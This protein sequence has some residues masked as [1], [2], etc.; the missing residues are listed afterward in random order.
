MGHR[1]TT[2]VRVLFIGFVVASSAS[3]SFLESPAS[4][5]SPS[6]APLPSALQL[7]PQGT[8][9]LDNATGTMD[10]ELALRPTADLDAY[11]NAV[12]TP[13]NPLYHQF[14]TNAEIAT[15]FGATPSTI[16]QLTSY[17]ASFGLT[18]TVGPTNLW[19][20]LRGPAPSIARAFGTSI[21]NAVV[22]GIGTRPEAIST[23]VVPSRFLT[24]IESVVGLTDYAMATN[25]AIPA[26]R[27]GPILHASDSLAQPA[28][29]VP[30]SGSAVCSAVGSNGGDTPSVLQSGY[31]FDPL[32]ANG[33]FGQGTTVGLVEFAD[34]A[35]SDAA[36]A[37]GCFGYS[38]TLANVN[39]DGGNTSFSVGGTTEVTA[40]IDTVMS[41]APKANID[42]YLAPNST[43]GYEAILQQWI[44][45][46]SVPILSSS[47][48]FCEGLAGSSS[49]ANSLDT[50]LAS[51]TASG[52]T[53]VVASG[54]YGPSGSQCLTQA[55][56][57]PA[58][59][60]H[61]LAVGGTSL[62]QYDTSAEVTWNDF[63][64]SAF[65]NNAPASG[66]GVST[67]FPA[68]SWQTTEGPGYLANCP[69][70]TY[71]SGCR[72]V[73][74]VS[75]NADPVGNYYS[76]Y[77]TQGCTGGW[78]G[79]GGTSLAT[80]LW[81]SGL[82][83]AEEACPSTTFGNVDPL[84]YQGASTQPDIFNDI[85][86]GTTANTT[87][88]QYFKAAVGYDMATGLG[89]P[90]FANLVDYLCGNSL[91]TA[92][93]GTP[94]PVSSVYALPAT[95]QG[96]SFST[97][98]GF[99]NNGFGTLV[100]SGLSSAG[101]ANQ[102]SGL[103]I[104]STDCGTTL[105]PGE[106]CT[107][108]V[109]G[110]ST[111]AGFSSA[112]VTLDGANPAM[113]TVGSST[114][115]SVVD[116]G[117]GLGQTGNFGSVALGTTATRT[118]TFANGSQ[119][120]SVTFGATP[121]TITGSQS[122]SIASTTCTSAS[123]SPGQTCQ[124]VVSFQPTQTGTL[125]SATL[126]SVSTAA[127]NVSIA[128][129]GAPANSLVASA[130]AVSIG[131]VGFGT[132]SS[133]KITLTA[134]GE[135]VTLGSPVATL[136]GSSDFEWS[137]GSCVPGSVLQANANC[138]LTVSYQPTHL[139][140]ENAS[141]TIH[142][143]AALGVSS[144]SLNATGVPQTAPPGYRM[145]NAAGQV[146]TFGELPNYGEVT[147][148]LNKPIVGMAN[149]PN[150]G[151]YWLVASDGGIFTFGDAQFYGSM[152]GHPLNKPVVGMT[153]TSD[154]AGYWMVASDGGIFTFGDAQFYGS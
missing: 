143:N 96:S 84:L 126:T 119:S 58:D 138:T 66:G 54:D 75:A 39:V 37:A 144:V 81:A 10:V 113:V 68:P 24:N 5:Q 100:G 69:S 101:L 50:L 77:C 136:T 44:Q 95:A 115:T 132:M 46:S 140:A 17:Y 114:T 147:W 9:F 8:T 62:P 12:A 129:S 107:A 88:A 59:S 74:D 28:D 48:G 123:L 23:P 19:V 64:G 127:S 1:W 16:T 76:F 33:Y 142:S 26:P 20:D 34:Y 112:T 135:A 139:G 21:S 13:G 7:A 98:I 38:G 145:V 86:S 63:N 56:T 31:Q 79:V 102:S 151:G 65:D 122:F 121:F 61:A 30:G 25:S 104:E 83:L 2:P 52:K 72:Q 87:T 35:S 141:L 42:V 15:R 90:R 116:G 108:F 153:P 120:S 128:L 110:T 92:G 3:L 137:N 131:D 6:L 85:T 11:A 103:T 149:L 32:Y 82:A 43:L 80:P 97:T 106:L 134:Y 73:P 40:D 105:Y 154:G 125:L 78:S 27:T 109:A 89:S 117:S 111:T 99:V 22:P 45:T 94:E 67:V 71:T 124:A 29:L 152:G 49:A 53:F 146:Y 41:L 130:T 47:W 148:P 133:S 93:V 91:P 118:L 150:G 36:T 60:P 57:I 4:A 70:A 14:L 18:T 51:A 55:V